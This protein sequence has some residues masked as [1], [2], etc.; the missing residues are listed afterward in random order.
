MA[1]L[2]LTRAFSLIVSNSQSKSMAR[3]SQSGQELTEECLMEALQLILVKLLCILRRCHYQDC[4]EWVI[5]NFVNGWYKLWSCRTVHKQASK[6]ISSMTSSNLVW[7]IMTQHSS[8]V[9]SKLNRDN[10]YKT[11]WKI[12][13]C[14]VYLFTGCYF[15]WL[16]CVVVEIALACKIQIQ[17]YAIF[18]L[19]YK[20]GW[21]EATRR[22]SQHE[23]IPS[24][25]TRESVM[26]KII[27]NYNVIFVVMYYTIFT[28]VYCSLR[29]EHLPPTFGPMYCIGSKF[30]WMS[31]HTIASFVWSLRSTPSSAMHIWGC[32]KASS[33]TLT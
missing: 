16:L 32:Y 28:C 25:V 8:T 1:H 14:A 24:V 2:A 29:K 3:Q 9:V 10:T 33:H 31:A 17:I 27:F 4:S 20:Y 13:L 15:C 19:W 6:F 21:S 11:C 30:T 7:T 18:D 22:S 26:I 12:F 5:A 23:Y